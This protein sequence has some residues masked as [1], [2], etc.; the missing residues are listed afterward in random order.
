VD[1]GELLIA[2]VHAVTELLRALVTAPD[3]IPDQ[4]LTQAQTAASASV[5]ER[6][7]EMLRRCYPT[8]P[9]SASLP[10]QRDL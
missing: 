7:A 1:D 9:H 4:L 2:I 10:P 8:R 6:C 5:R 3:A